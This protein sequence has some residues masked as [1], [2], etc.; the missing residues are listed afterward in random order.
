MRAVEVL[1]LYYFA[2][3]RI[4]ASDMA[5]GQSVAMSLYTL[6]LAAGSWIGGEG[7]DL[8]GIHGMYFLA[9]LAAVIGTLIINI[10]ISRTALQ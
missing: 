5:K 6:G 3:E 8:F 9:V 4:P 1:S 7:V 10:F 2:K